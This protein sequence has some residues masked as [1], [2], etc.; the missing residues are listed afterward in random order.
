[1]IHE[2]SPDKRYRTYGICSKPM[3]L[4]PKSKLGQ[5]FL[6]DLICLTS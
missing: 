3:V 1:M 6:I 5:C 2:P 4:K